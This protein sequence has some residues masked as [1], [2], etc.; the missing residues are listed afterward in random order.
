MKVTAALVLDTAPDPATKAAGGR[1]A[2]RKARR[3]GPKP[4]T[5]GA[6]PLTVAERRFKAQ[7]DELERPSRVARR[8]LPVLQMPATRD[9]CA[10]IPRPCPYVRC[11]M[12]NYLTTSNGVVQRAYP[13]LEP[14]EIDPKW[15]CALDVADRGGAT[16][17]EIGRAINVTLERVRQI[18]AGAL[19][20]LAAASPHLREALE[21]EGLLSES[22]FAIARGGG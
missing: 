13:N 17:E 16:V 20:K 7:L 21:E 11:S 22:D 15:S 18:H 2:R 19:R 3:N 14:W 9:G 4:R 1:T 8:K 6:N 5:L 12:N 10:N